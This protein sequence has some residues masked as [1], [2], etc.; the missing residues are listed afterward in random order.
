M[1]NE[2][3]MHSIGKL[4]YVHVKN[5]I[6]HE[7]GFTKDYIGWIVDQ[8]VD[9]AVEKYLNRK[10][11]TLNLNELATTLLLADHKYW[12]FKEHLVEAVRQVVERDLSAEFKDISAGVA[13]LSSTCDATGVKITVNIH[14]TK[15]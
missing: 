7:L 14:T 6:Q 1:S 2:V 12:G 11:Q 5:F 8:H 13:K 3:T 15:K 4:A 9:K 10:L